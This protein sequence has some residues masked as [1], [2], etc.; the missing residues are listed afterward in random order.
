MVKYASSFWLWI[1]MYL[2]I[3]MSTVFV[4]VMSP[5]P[6][7]P[8]ISHVRLSEG[9]MSSWLL[10]VG[11]MGWRSEMVPPTNIK[12][13]ANTLNN[14]PFN[15]QHVSTHCKVQPAGQRTTFEPG[16]LCVRVCMYTS[17]SVLPFKWSTSLW[18]EPDLKLLLMQIFNM[19]FLSA[20]H[21]TSS[22]VLLFCDW[23]RV[24]MF[25]ISKDK[26]SNMNT[27]CG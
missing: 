26:V 14:V 8:S 24:W 12:I 27:Q 7:K 15:F 5:V 10:N 1:M 11:I 9:L 16:I 2:L 18:T 17:Y 4:H 22:L 3:H 21:L 19:L 20:M 6:A 13:A 25:P 23:K